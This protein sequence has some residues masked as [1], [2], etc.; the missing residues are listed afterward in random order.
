MATIRKSVYLCFIHLKRTAALLLNRFEVAGKRKTSKQAN[1]NR[2]CQDCYRQENLKKKKG[3]EGGGT[4]RGGM[5]GGT[6]GGTYGG[7]DIIPS[8][9]PQLPSMNIT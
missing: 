4:T 1:K 5:K 3:K 2:K 8:G 6:E 9:K 7:R